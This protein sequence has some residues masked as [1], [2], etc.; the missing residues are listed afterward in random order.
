MSGAETLHRMKRSLAGWDYNT[1][2]TIYMIT[3]TLQDRTH[4]WLGRLDLAKNG[5]AQD[6]GG[7]GPGHF[8]PGAWR[9]APTAS[10][11]RAST[12]SPERPQQN[13]L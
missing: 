7:S 2:R 9:I 13:H 4:D 5:E 6:K 8:C 11:R 1:R 10:S 12:R 3:L